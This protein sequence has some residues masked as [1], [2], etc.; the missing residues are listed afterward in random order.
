M[1]GSSSSSV[2]CRTATRT[3]CPSLAIFGNVSAL[4][5]AMRMSGHGLIRLR[6]EPDVFEAVVLAVIGEGRLGPRSLEDFQSLGKALA[7][8]AVRYAIS[9]VGP[10]ETTPPDPENQATAADLVDRCGLFGQPQRMTERQ[11][12]NASSYLHALGAG[13]D[14]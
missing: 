9:F 6:G 3:P 10:G 12:L 8:F 7:A 1:F 4:L 13:G 14:G 5:A 11:Y 2:P